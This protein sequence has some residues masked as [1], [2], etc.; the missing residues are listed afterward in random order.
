MRARAAAAVVLT[1]AAYLVL[2]VSAASAAACPEPIPVVAHRGGT[3]RYA[4]NTLKAFRHAQNLGALW[5]EAD[6]RATAP[7]DDLPDGE[8]VL[9]HDATVDRTTDGTGAVADLTYEEIRGLHTDD[10]QRVP[11]LRELLADADVDGAKVLVEVKYD[12]TPQQWAAIRDAIDGEGM[13]GRVVVMAFA[14]SVPIAELRAETVGRAAGVVEDPGYRPVG[15]YTAMGV[16][17]LIKHQDSITAAR[18]DEWSGPLSV[19]AWTVDSVTGWARMQWYTAEP[20]RLDLVITNK[21][22]AYLAWARERV[23]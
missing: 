19:A 6:V 4:E 23:C 22:G 16:T 8:Q 12:P 21:P 10:G 17:W 14:S 2:P 18:L 20:G 3:E 11:T 13:T 7:S 9:M 15:D 1:A 5:W